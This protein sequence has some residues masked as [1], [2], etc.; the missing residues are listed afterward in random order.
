MHRLLV[1][2]VLL[3]S[4]C[5]SGSDPDAAALPAAS[6]SVAVRLLDVT[7][8]GGRATGVE[9][10]VDAQAGERLVLKITSDS[11]EEVHVH[12]YDLYADLAPGRAAQLS[13]PADLLGSYVVEL[14]RAQRP[15]FQ[16]RVG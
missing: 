4:G 8:A 7:L 16:L 5:S 13:F 12:G 15:L 9:Q 6:P 1:A 10:R 11:A 3:L 14:H 2:L